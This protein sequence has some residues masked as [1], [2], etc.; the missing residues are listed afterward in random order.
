[1]CSLPGLVWRHLSNEGINEIGGLCR[2]YS[3]C[4]SLPHS[5]CSLAS[6]GHALKGPSGSGEQPST[7]SRPKESLPLSWLRDAP[8]REIPELASQRIARMESALGGVLR[9]KDEVVRLSVVCL[10]ARGHLLIEDVPG[11]WQRR[12]WRK[13]WPGLRRAEF[14]R[15]QCTSDMLP[16][17][18]LGVTVLQRQDWR[19]RVSPRANIYEFSARRRDQSCD[20]EERSRRCLRQ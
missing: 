19:I 14:Q 6:C 20:A 10:L 2:L 18:I 9:G 16:G 15:L 7:S 13:A 5:A 8:H 1:M 3:T 4:K 17:D 12:R 11:R